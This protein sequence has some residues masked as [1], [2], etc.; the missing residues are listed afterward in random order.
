MP[1]GI[2]TTETTSGARALGSAATAVIGLVVTAPDADPTAFPLDTPVLITSPASAASALGASG[3]GRAALGAI[4]DQVASCPVVIVRVA[5]GADDAHTDVAV[6][7]ADLGGVKTGLQALLSGQAVTGVRPR[8]LGAPGLDTP[9]VA[10]ALATLAPKL[11]AFAYVQ[12]HG[13]T[14]VGAAV[15]YR[16]TFG[17]R[18]LMVIWPDFTISGASASVIGRALGLRAQIDQTQGWHKTLSNVPVAGVTG[19]DPGVSYDLH[20][21][22]SDAAIL[23]A[24]DVTTLIQDDG[25][26][27]WGSR[28][29]SADAAYTFESSVRTSQVL[30]DM[31]ADGLKW[32]ADKPLHPSLAKDIV[33][34][35]NAG[36]RALKAQERIIG[37]KAW[38]DPA[39][40]QQGDL[41]AGKL[42]IVYDFTPVPPLEDLELTQVLTD[43]YFAD[44][45][46]SATGQAS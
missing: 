45:V 34:T 35:I 30:K 42:G 38:I 16:A 21:V 37:G 39:A 15:A 11:N 13:C 3:T 5:P 24:A 28:T 31:V 8:I 26:R 19:I 2:F 6:V 33:E 10:A 18:E 23:N 9:A 27:F 22:A 25:F 41:A 36:F 14:T 4:A 29:C 44:F 40:N 32:A 1:H 17:A 12:A 46:A 7:G 20:S 43:S